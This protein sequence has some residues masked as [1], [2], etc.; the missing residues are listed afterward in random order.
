MRRESPAEIAAIAAQRLERLRASVPSDQSAP[1]APLAVPV[2]HPG[3]HALHRPPPA[4][5]RVAAWAGRRLPTLAGSARLRLGHLTGL[6]LVAAL[7]L[8]VTAWWAVHRGSPTVPVAAPVA[9][10][11][12]RTTG[13]SAPG[14][15]AGAS[16]DA[17]PVALAGSATPS[18]VA[19]SGTVVVDVAGKVRRPGI[20]SLPAGSRVVEALRRAGGARPGVD[21]TS[22]NLA[23]ILI[24]GEQLL[25]G[26]SPGSGAG[27]AAASGSA[28][29]SAPVSATQGAS[30]DTTGVASVN[31]NT[32][33]AE[34]LDE[35]PGV[36]PV[37]AQKII[38]WRTEH[39][40][41]RSVDELLEV[42]G[43]GPKTLAELAPRATL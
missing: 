35:L 11:A 9:S 33:T 31:L 14:P 12:A 23:R 34:G 25:V 38:A 42:D 13:G 32:A 6:L 15:S 4:P 43:I 18:P 29:A 27:S 17:A 3:R 1:A 20:V 5:S 21:L 19:A 7:V 37:T 39:G 36:G 26:V 2:P 24:D 8:A 41:F 22:L 16:A 40:A 10:P 28:P 30:A